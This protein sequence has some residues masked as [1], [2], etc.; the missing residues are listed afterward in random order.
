MGCADGG[1]D[2]GYVGG[3]MA[4]GTG[5]AA[6]GGD[7]GNGGK[8]ACQ[9]LNALPLGEAVHVPP[10][11]APRSAAPVNTAHSAATCRPLTTA[12]AP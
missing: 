6:G 2:G 7:A 10:I 4:G 3:G 5:G 12:T 8:V 11:A 1:G 9:K